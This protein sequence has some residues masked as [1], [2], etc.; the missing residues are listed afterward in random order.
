MGRMSMAFIGGHREGSG[1]SST[2]RS[3]S[4]RGRGRVNAARATLRLQGEAQK[5]H[6]LP[7]G[8]KL[9]TRQR[10]L[11]GPGFFFAGPR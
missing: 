3:L 2:R 4:E 11:Q 5:A 1:L 8:R 9:L 6:A 7:L 10:P